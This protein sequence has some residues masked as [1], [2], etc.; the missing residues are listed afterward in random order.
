MAQGTA[1]LMLDACSHVWT[2]KSLRILNRFARRKLADFYQRHSMTSYCLALSY[3]V[4]GSSIGSRLADMYIDWPVHRRISSIV[5]ADI[6]PMSVSLDSLLA[7]YETIE[8]AADCLDTILAD[9]TFLGMITM[10]YQV[11]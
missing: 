5:D 10:Q 8:T 7:D 4:S 2:G 11:C 3:R 6:D 1:D 9:H